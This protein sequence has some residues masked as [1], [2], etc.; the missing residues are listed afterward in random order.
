MTGEVGR[1]T[2]YKPEYAKQ[3]AKLCALGATDSDLSEFFEV[4]RSTINLWKIEFPQFSDAL[5]LGKAPADDR[6][7]A[8]LYHRAVGYSHPDVDIKVIDGKIVTTEIIKHYPPDTTACIFWLKNRLPDEFRANPEDIGGSKEDK[9][10]DA[11]S[12]LINKLP[13]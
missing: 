1:P 6:V 12:E 10:L 4:S 5:K 2:K 3:A 13:N 9:L 11:V 7:K 8:S